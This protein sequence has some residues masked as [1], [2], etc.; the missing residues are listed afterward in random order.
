MLEQ[1]SEKYYRL[2]IQSAMVLFALEEALGTYV[3][4]NAHSPEAIPESMRSEIQKRASEAVTLVSATQLVQETYIKEIIDLAL[5]T[6]N[7]LSDHEPLRR[8]NRLVE[9]LEIFDI[10]NA[11]CHPNRPFPECFW[12]RTA[13]LATD[14][15]IE[16][17]RLHR[18]TDAFRCAS[19]G[20]LVP[21]PDGWLKQQA[22]IVANNLPS[23]FDHAVTGLIAR[24][25]ETADL[26]RRLANPRNTYLALVGPGGT[27]KTAL[28]LE[29]LRDVALDP[30]TLQWADQIAYVSAKTER[31]TAR[32]VEPI[33]DPVD[34]IES[35]KKVIASAILGEDVDST[36]EGQSRAFGVAT[37]RF[38]KRRVL[39]CIDNLE[40]LLRDHAEKF[41]EM[42]Q[43]LPTAWHILVT[44]RVTV[45]GAN[46]LTL[47]PIKPSGA[48]KL[49]RDYLSIRGVAPLPEDQLL[50]VVDV[51]DRNPL[52]IRLTID[53]YAAGAE[54]AG[55]LTQ[56]KER[57]LEYSYTSLLERL[58]PEA[59]KVLECLFGSAVPQSRSEIGHLLELQPD[60][61]AEA[62]NSLVR[63]S[64]VT[65]Q[66]ET[67]IERY[68]LSSSVRDLLLKAP[69][70]PAVR[71][72]VQARLRE[73]NRL[74][75][76]LEQGGSGDPLAEDF[77]PAEA[78][79]HVRA[80]ITR[81]KRSLRGQAGRAD[82]LSHLTELRGA[83]AF[84]A[85]EAVLYRAEALLLKQLDDRFAAIDSLS[86]AVG[87]AGD[88]WA[89]RL[90]L[91][92][93]LRGEQRLHEALEQ[94]EQLM[95]AKLLENGAVELRNRI[96]LLRAHWVTVL[97]EKRFAEVM[98]ATNNWKSA[99]DLRSTLAALRISTFQRMLDEMTLTPSDRRDAVC[100]VVECL[101]ETFRLDGYQGGLVHEAFHAV[102]KLAWLGRRQVL[103]SEEVALCAGLLNRHLR[104][105]CAVHRDYSRAS[106]EVVDLVTCFRDLP[107]AGTNPLKEASWSELIGFAQ[108]HDPALVKA[109]YEAAT[110]T[111][112]RP[113]G[114]YAFARALD[115]SRDFYVKAAATELS[116]ADFGRLRSGQPV[117]VL[118]ADSFDPA[119]GRA[120][121]AKHVMLA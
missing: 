41:E 23:T 75:S 83:L 39:L 40:T 81:M 9:A 96:R 72:D 52:A 16:S 6:A 31:L 13:S 29:L 18:V 58:L 103:T 94:T 119:S 38:A 3:V 67:G 78:P 21:P 14:L 95:A 70:N 22:W 54:L 98:A 46:V 90:M 48:M 61:V 7:D 86:K 4:Q 114:D 111:Y 112:V 55:A 60:E 27:G 79:A 107:C 62:L 110:L 121:P 113:N 59:G 44:S 99:G 100:S 8:I 106:S 71:S 64:L 65:R 88:D 43:E 1:A 89:S 24:K 28:C 118:A 26:K 117:W 12:Y 10:R 57:I 69:R 66:T 104:D 73:Q 33:E 15:A 63:T 115:G 77:V 76:Q 56:T 108:E 34:S 105:M 85:K 36:E 87:C 32:G 92:E 68:A 82:Q 45:N 49:A 116:V 47:G 25:D 74:L 84:D 37:T 20:R 109:G 93:L 53:S 102:E 2:R 5:A 11:V 50:R 17:L 101:D 35:A 19:E 91:A 51:C 30:T 42:V 97:W 120:W 80:L